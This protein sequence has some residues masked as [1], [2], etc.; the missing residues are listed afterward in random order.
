MAVT[1][2]NNKVRT[3]KEHKCFSCFRKFPP[4]TKMNYWAGIY[5]GDF[6][7][8]YYCNTCDKIMQK[9]EENEYPEGFVYEML[10][11][12]QTPEDLLI[13]LYLNK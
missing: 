1:L 2:Q 6:N 8:V 4:K 11:K 13:D 3:R 5:E 10:D 12:N 9:D 7:S